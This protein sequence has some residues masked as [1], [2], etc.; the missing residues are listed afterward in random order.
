MKIKEE[1]TKQTGVVLKKVFMVGHSDCT[2][3][4]EIVQEVSFWGELKSESK[5]L[6]SF[7]GDHY[8]NTEL[9]ALEHIKKL[10]KP[11]CIIQEIFIKEIK[12]TK[13]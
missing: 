1:K 11:A 4:E 10:D 2:F 7:I 12:T 6:L 13:E 3:G 5:Q 9:E 8:F